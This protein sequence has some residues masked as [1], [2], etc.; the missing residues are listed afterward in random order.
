[1]PTSSEGAHAA[2]RAGISSSLAA[3]KLPFIANQGQDAAGVKYTARTFAGTVAVTD[4]GRLRYSLPKASPRSSLSATTA[5]LQS[6]VLDE[7]F[8]GGTA[9]DIAAEDTATPV[10]NRFHGNDPRQWQTALPTYQTVSLGEVY[11]GIA[12]KLQAHGYSVEK[13]FRVQPGADPSDLRL[14]FNGSDG[15]AIT[16]G[17]ELEVTTGLGPVRFSEPVAYQLINGNRQVVEVSYTVVAD[18]YGFKLGNYDRSRELVI[19]PILISTFIG[20][21]DWDESF[22]IAVNAAGEVYVTGLTQ[23]ADLPGIGVTS[24]DQVFAGVI[25]ADSPQ[26]APGQEGFV[27]KLN[28]NLDALLAVTFIGGSHNDSAFAITLDGTGNVYVAGGTYSADFPGVTAASP[29]STVSSTDGFVVKLNSTLSTILGATLLGGTGSEYVHAMVIDTAGNVYVAGHTSSTDFPGVTAASADPV[30]V[31]IEGFVAKLNSGLTTIAA[32]TFLGGSDY[33]QIQSITLGGGSTLYTAGWTRSTDFP[34]VSSSSAD[35]I[36]AG[37]EAFVA[38]LNTGLTSIVAATYVGGSDDDTGTSL[39]VNSAGNVYLAGYTESA[40]L[41]G[42]SATSADATNGA[43]RDGFVTRLSAGLNSILRTTYLGGSHSDFAYALALDS[44]GNLYVAGNTGSDDFPGVGPGAADPVP[45]S[46]PLAGFRT[47]YIAKLNGALTSIS[48]ATF[49][50]GE[51]VDVWTLAI[52]ATGNVLAAGRTASSDFPGVVPASADSTFANEGD[53]YDGYEGFV[54]KLGPCPISPLAT[55]AA[56]ESCSWSDPAGPLFEPSRVD[57]SI[58]DCCPFCPGQ[59]VLR[60]EIYA[61]GAPLTR[62]VLRFEGL[63]AAAVQRIGIEGPA[64][65]T[66]QGRLVMTAGN[67]VTLRGLPQPSRSGPS[68]RMAVETVMFSAA[69][70]SRTQLAVTEFVDGKVITKKT[71]KYIAY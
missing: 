12:V 50:G 14:K 29:D 66:P 55:G 21:S 18:T 46:H 53:Y 34:G 6:V 57:C 26:K 43:G 4:A 32:A 10:V 63:D 7:E 15:L 56:L 8:V 39:A 11:P 33:D 47:G 1:M 42:V 45:T 59:W 70:D 23:F 27:A 35:S 51:G 60:W 68:F 3:L 48:S 58:I 16:A 44:T 31:G 22:G 20:G 49:L 40:D 37:T 2:A 54:A 38:R 5:A 24:A 13:I 19:D 67:K 62:L 71:L 64:Y 61:T 30:R 28:P 9:K 36:A 17:G 41:P 52:D 69:L 65:W 25:D